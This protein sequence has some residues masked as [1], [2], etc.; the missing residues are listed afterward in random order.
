MFLHL[1]GTPLKTGAGTLQLAGDSNTSVHLSQGA[2]QISSS[3]SAVHHTITAEG[4]TLLGGAALWETI[5]IPGTLTV[6]APTDLSLWGPIS[7]SGS[8]IKRGTGTLTF[9]NIYYENTYTGL[10][11]VNEGTL[12][13]QRG[14]V[15]DEDDVAIRGSLVIG[16]GIGGPA[17]DVV[18]VGYE[19]IRAAPAN[20]CAGSP[21]AHVQGAAGARTTARYHRSARERNSGPC[22]TRWPIPP[23]TRPPEAEIARLQARLSRVEPELAAAYARWEQLEEIAR[24]SGG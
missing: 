16:D 5:E 11:T 21:Q 3:S 15:N 13:L 14:S 4:G 19:Q 1:R 12:V 7:G 9:G 18:L 17:A 2:V 23:C 8:L 6:N 10:T 20:M 24:A 22:T